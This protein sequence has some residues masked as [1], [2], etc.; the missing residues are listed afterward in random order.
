MIPQR[1]LAR[2]RG[3]AKG[4]RGEGDKE[5]SEKGDKESSE[6]EWEERRGEVSPLMYP[7]VAR[8]SLVERL[9]L[10]LP[11]TSNARRSDCLPLTGMH[12]HPA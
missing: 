5:S 1:L 9:S 2:R 10:R 4:E 6:R 3:P 12:V 8:C 7:R 11:L